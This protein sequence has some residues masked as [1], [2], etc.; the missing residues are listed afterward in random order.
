MF[1]R[2]CIYDRYQSVSKIG[3][4]GGE[5]FHLDTPTCNA[6]RKWGAF[7]TS[8]VATDE[9]GKLRPPNKRILVD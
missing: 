2:R 3:T 8:F 6:L 7:S 9:N 5:A 1:T 4:F